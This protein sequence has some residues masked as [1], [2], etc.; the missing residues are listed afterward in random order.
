MKA[1]T[2]SLIPFHMV[3]DSAILIIERFEEGEIFTC[4]LHML[5]THLIFLESF[6]DTGRANLFVSGESPMDDPHDFKDLVQKMDRIRGG[7]S[8]ILKT[9]PGVTREE[10]ENLERRYGTII[11]DWFRNNIS[12]HT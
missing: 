11:G 5:A 9:S 12:H 2:Q 4:S 3:A 6:I 1:H 7:I 10:H 8:T